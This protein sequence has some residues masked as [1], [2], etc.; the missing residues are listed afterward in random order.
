MA[1]VSG[2][3]IGA[4]A[5]AS[6][7]NTCNELFDAFEAAHNYEHDYQ[8]A[9]NKLDVLRM[10]LRLWGRC[11]DTEASDCTHPPFREHW[12]LQNGTIER[13][14]L[15]IQTIL[16][17]STML[18]ERYR[19]PPQREQTSGDG[20][21]YTITQP[22]GVNISKSSTH[23]LSFFRRRTLWA[24]HDKQKFDKLI[25]DLT[26][27]IEN[28]EQV[29]DRLY[30]SA[31]PLEPPLWHPDH[32][33]STPMS[34]EKHT[35]DSSGPRNLL[36]INDER[37]S[38]PPPPPEAW[39]RPR[40][41]QSPGQTVIDISGAQHNNNSI[42]LQGILGQ[43]PGEYRG[44]ITQTNCHFSFGIQ[45][46]VASASDVAMLQDRAYARQNSYR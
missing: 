39:A 30:I 32:Q 35:I 11:L 20:I 19:L 16:R 4:V 26:F 5:L 22:A 40:A 15:D 36:F 45:G 6:L 37:Y 7:F 41:M 21:G 3:V 18:A 44:S 25:T 43:I 34:S 27:L 28:L 24:I 13:S 23:R 17:N 12:L 42:G 38:A 9:C 29:T 1:E 10:R 46:V 8:L 31:R 14:L 2:L 33:P